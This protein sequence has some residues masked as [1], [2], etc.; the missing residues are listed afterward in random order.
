MGR[1][2][3]EHTVLCVVVQLVLEVVRVH[4][5]CVC[6]GECRGACDG[7]A[8]RGSNEDACVF[9][10]QGSVWECADAPVF[11]QS[12]VH[13]QV[14][15]AERF[16]TRNPAAAELADGDVCRSKSAGPAESAVPADRAAWDVSPGK[17]PPVHHERVV[18]CG[19]HG[20]HGRNRSPNCVQAGDMCVDAATSYELYG[21]SYCAIMLGGWIALAVLSKI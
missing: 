18:F 19:V 13:Q 5:A 10:A 11:L 9:V 12:C 16:R 20:V 15:V 1:A 6:G 4:E 7:V 2:P 17:L 14:A 3:F 8:A 21:V